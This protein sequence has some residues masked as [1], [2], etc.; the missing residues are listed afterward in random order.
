MVAGGN[1]GLVEVQFPF[2]TFE[3]EWSEPQGMYIQ[4]QYLVHSR[5]FQLQHQWRAHTSS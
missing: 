3:A 4:P 1:R 5:G 2:I